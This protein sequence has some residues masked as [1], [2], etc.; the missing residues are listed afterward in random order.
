MSNIVE[1][2]QFTGEQTPDFFRA[3]AAFDK[4]VA[5]P[6]VLEKLEE[7]ERLHLAPLKIEVSESNPGAHYDF[8]QHTIYCNPA[9]VEAQTLLTMAGQPSQMTLERF[10][11]HEIAHSAQAGV[12]DIAE[13]TARGFEIE[14]NHASIPAIRWKEWEGIAHDEKAVRARAAEVYDAVI[15]NRYAEIGAA[16][17][18]DKEQDP[19][20]QKFIKEYEIP[21]MTFENAIAAKLNQPQRKLDYLHSACDPGAEFSRNTFIES[22]TAAILDIKKARDKRAGQDPQSI[23]PDASPKGGAIQLT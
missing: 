10:F 18:R 1:R 9:Y 21:A 7:A 15:G 8:N 12:G 20:I 19:I 6:E 17:L 22:R 3:K 23:R 13:A 4:V 2:I 16:I 5:Y 11:A 14:G